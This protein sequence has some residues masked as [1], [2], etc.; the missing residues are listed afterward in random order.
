MFFLLVGRFVL[1]TCEN[2]WAFIPKKHQHQLSL[3]WNEAYGFLVNF[4]I[5]NIPNS[6]PNRWLHFTSPPSFPVPIPCSVGLFP[7]QARNMGSKVQLHLTSVNAENRAMRALE[8]RNG[9]RSLPWKLRA[10]KLNKNPLGKGK[11]STHTTNFFRFHVSFR[12]CKGLWNL[13]KIH[14]QGEGY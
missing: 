8:E 7:S 9:E 3:F 1:E 10:G 4:S 6:K 2:A 12:G 13:G 11:T 5:P 14:L